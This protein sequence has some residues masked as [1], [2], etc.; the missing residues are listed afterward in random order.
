[1]SSSDP[2]RRGPSIP[3]TLRWAGLGTAAQ[4]ALALIVAVILVIRELAGHHE[5][6]ISGYGTAVWFVVI[7]GA[8]LA[9]GLALTRGRRWGRGLSLITQLLLL[10]TGYTIITG[11]YLLEAGLSR[12]LGYPIIAVALVLLALLFAPAST[13]WLDADDLPPDA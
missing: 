3:K 1:M 8:V 7:G 2:V 12:W 13:S 6:G 10:P 5:V 11:D 4:G 9:G